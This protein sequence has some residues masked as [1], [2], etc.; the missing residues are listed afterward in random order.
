MRLKLRR[1][2]VRAGSDRW[3]LPLL[4]IS[5]FSFFEVVIKHERRAILNDARKWVEREPGPPGR[6]AR[7]VARSVSHCVVDTDFFFDRIQQSLIEADK[8]QFASAAMLPI[9]ELPQTGSR[10]GVDRAGPG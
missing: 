5:L 7:V 2:I 9:R 4:V 6:E 1:E 3:A 10:G 8:V